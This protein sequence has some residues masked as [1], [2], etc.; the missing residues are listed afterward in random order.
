MSK[1]DQNNNPPNNRTP[2]PPFQG[3]GSN[4]KDKKP[5]SSVVM[6]II[7]SAI[8]L[9]LGLIWFGSDAKSGPKDITWNKLETVLLN[10]DEEKIIVVNKEF[11]E[12][13]IKQEA[14]DR[15][16]TYKELLGKTSLGKDNAKPSFY[17]YEFVTFESV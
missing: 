13:Y 4:S 2:H 16:S 15:D 8:I 3:N 12:I 7:Y 1:K 17:R 5:K 14:L 6:Y 9:A 11:A 10:Q